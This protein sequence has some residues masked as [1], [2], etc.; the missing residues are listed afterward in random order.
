VER[1]NPALLSLKGQHIDPLFIE[2][3]RLAQ[4]NP[5][6][7]DVFSSVGFDDSRY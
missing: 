4:F 7:T 3:H 6:G 1:F 5:R 2:V